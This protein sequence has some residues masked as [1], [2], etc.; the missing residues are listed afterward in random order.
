MPRAHTPVNIFWF[1]RDLRLDDNVGLA[2]ALASG[3]KVLPLF[4]F[5]TEILAKLK[6]R[7]DPRVGFIHRALQTLERELRENGSGLLV[8]HGKPIEVWRDIV[9]NHQVLSV[10]TNRD[11]E[12]YA[13]ERDQEVAK[14]LATKGIEFHDS[15]DQVIFEKDEVEKEVGG[16]YT[17]FTP[18]YRKWLANLKD[19]H[20]KPA[21]PKLENLHQWKPAKFPLLNEIGFRE[22]RIEIPEPRLEKATLKNYARDR[23][24]LDLDAT[25]RVGPHLRFGT[26]SIREVA[27]LAR[28]ASETWLKELVWREFFMQILYYFPHV[29]KGAFRPE[30][31]KI[32]FL[33]NEAEF[34]AWC[35]GKTGVPVVDAGMRELNSTGFMHNRA[36]MITA[37]FLVKQL[38]ID[39]R[40]GE[41]YF[42]RRLLDFELASNNGNWQWC[43]GT[44][45]DA[46]PYFRIFNPETQAKK[47]DPEGAYIK[48]WC[49]EYVARTPDPIVD[50]KTARVRALRAYRSAL[51]KT[52]P[53]PTRK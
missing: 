5:D 50:N 53:K 42:A 34:K 1:R 46:A 44:G 9:A 39:W 28:A 24:R 33:N 23:D 12:P 48:R 13:I 11:Y 35:E 27:K 51:D 43:A 17:V 29:T 41:A 25:S 20:L 26:L 22:P 3:V 14:F 8:K 31:D 10:Y 21:K 6:D 49:P 18:Y 15:K 36:R 45:C 47:F 38:L 37:S 52:A 30:Y 32:Q 4:I 2:D 40:W 19:A 16:P 7:D